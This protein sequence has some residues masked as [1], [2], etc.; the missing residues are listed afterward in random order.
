MHVTNQGGY[1]KLMLPGKLTKG[2]YQNIKV[3]LSSKGQLMKYL[4]LRLPSIYLV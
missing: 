2:P 1:T 4:T 3:T